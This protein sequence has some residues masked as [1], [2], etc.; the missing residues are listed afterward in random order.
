MNKAV[1][2][3]N[4]ARDPEMRTTST[5]KSVCNFTLAVNPKYAKDRPA[6]FI[7][8][9][10]W[11]RIGESCAKYLEKGSKVAVIGEIH[12]RTYDTSDGSKRY[13]MEI[14]ADEVKFLSMKKA[15]DLPPSPDTWEDADGED[16]PF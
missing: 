13:V 2:I 6:S 3:G 10:A 9:V 15:T 16:L 5:G 11:D 7:T 12:T 4:L 8:I 14:W 1:L